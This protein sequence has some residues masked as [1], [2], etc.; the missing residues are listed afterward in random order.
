MIF[1][2]IFYID[3]Q[4]YIYDQEW[5]EK[6]VPIEFI[7]FRSFIYSQDLIENIPLNDV[8]EYFNITE[9]NIGLFQKL[10]IELQK[11]TRDKIA[12]KLNS[13][14]GVTERRLMEKIDNL[15]ADKEKISQEC[16]N[17]LI[18][19]DGRIHQLETNLSETNN[20]L[21][22]REQELEIMKKSKSWKITEPLRKLKK[23]RQ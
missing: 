23:G 10:D 14:N 4:Y 2:N 20:I 16:R 11:K 15:E 17:L 7:I 3:D 9:K 22:Q 6:N 19:K 5:M 8:W 12:W 13:D 18:E 1:Q 21:L